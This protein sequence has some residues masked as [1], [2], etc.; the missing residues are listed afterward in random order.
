M[1]QLPIKALMDSAQAA[2]WYFFS[3]SVF[4]CVVTS[5]FEATTAT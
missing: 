1:N 4:G 3:S 2:H 5:V